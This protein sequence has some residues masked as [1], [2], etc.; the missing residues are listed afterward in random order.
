M[1]AVTNLSVKNFRSHKNFSTGLSPKVTVITGKNGSGKTSLIEAI[2]VALQGSSFKGSDNDLVRTNSPWWRVDVSLSDGS[3]RSITF[4]PQKSERKKSF[5]IDKKTSYRLLQKFR[6]PI[7][8]FEPDDLR[9]IN[10]S[11]SRRRQFIDRFICQV[12]PAYRQVLRK[13]ERALSQRNNLLKRGASYD[14]LF[15][16][17]VALSEYGAEIIKQRKNMCEQINSRLNAAYNSISKTDDNISVYYSDISTGDAGHRLLKELSA[18]NDHDR[19]TGSTSV[20]P[21]RHDIIFE[22][23][24]FLASAMASR[25]ETR[26]IVVALKLIEASMVSEI[27]GQDPIIMLDDVFSELDEDRQSSI[28]NKINQYQVIITDTKLPENDVNTVIL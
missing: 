21:H 19:Y 1:V 23:N 25:G 17:D 24:T 3:K 10:G 15:V 18:S 11:P 22:L 27:Y 16:W 28:T 4:D 2:Y 7:V 6:I 12:E 5:N 26:T 20:G 9:L 8:L 14:S 13:Y